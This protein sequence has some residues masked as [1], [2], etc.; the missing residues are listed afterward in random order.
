[1][2]SDRDRFIIQ[3]GELQRYPEPEGV[4]YTVRD[5]HGRPVEIVTKSGERI[6]ATYDDEP[7]DGSVSAPPA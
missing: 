4:D 1:M 5:E 7:G 3:P 2:T 6:Y